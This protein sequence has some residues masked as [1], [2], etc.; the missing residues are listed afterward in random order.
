MPSGEVVSGSIVTS[1]KQG[2]IGQTAEEIKKTGIG[3][4]IADRFHDA[5]TNFMDAKHPIQQAVTELAKVYKSN[6]GNTLI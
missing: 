4:T 2:A 3:N 1:K 5:Y 6:T